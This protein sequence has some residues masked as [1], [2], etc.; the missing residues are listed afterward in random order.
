MRRDDGLPEVDRL[1]ARDPAAIEAVVT[2]HAR[3][4]YRAARGLGF[5]AH[6]AEDLT[7]DVFVTF[8][9]TIERY[10]ARSAVG[11]WLMGILHHKAQEQWRSN[12]RT[13]SADPL[14]D[15]FEARFNSDG[16]WSRPPVPADRRVE[17]GQTAQALRDCLAGLTG[18]QR[19]VFHLREVEALPAGDVGHLLG[20][21]ANHVGVLFHRARTT[22]RACLETKGWGVVR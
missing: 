13:E 7:Q 8:L 3:R 1:R 4:L 2:V 12:A 6:D 17:A 22:L 18:Q 20:C 15:A 21:T 9:Q 14:D 11:T 5:S 19:A 10:E 16:S